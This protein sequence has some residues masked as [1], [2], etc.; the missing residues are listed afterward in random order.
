[1]LT[2]YMYMHGHL[3]MGILMYMHGHLGMGILMYMYFLVLMY[4]Y[5]HLQLA[6]TK[7]GTISR[8]LRLHK[9]KYNKVNTGIYPRVP[10]HNMRILRA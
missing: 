2:S 5:G 1:M 8:T 4:M 6:S 9:Y 3:G 10:K 7:K